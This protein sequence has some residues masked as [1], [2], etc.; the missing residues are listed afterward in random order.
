MTCNS[1]NAPPYVREVFS[2]ASGLRLLHLTLF[3][4]DLQHLLNAFEVLNEAL[5]QTAIRHRSIATHPDRLDLQFQCG[6]LIH[7]D[8]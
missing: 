6:S 2:S 8:Q 3:V 7:H 5:A 4:A 1:L